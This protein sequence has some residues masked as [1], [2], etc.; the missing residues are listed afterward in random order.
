MP[1]DDKK[2]F[3][4]RLKT[5]LKRLPKSIETATELA[6]QFNLKHQNEP[7]TPQAAQKWLQGTAFPTTDKLQ[8]LA[9]WL[10]VSAHWLKNGT[11]PTAIPPRSIECGAITETGS[12]RPKG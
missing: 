11:P 6:H 8:T 12:P 3:A 4:E 9:D 5:A 1:V 10:N 2:A 7:I